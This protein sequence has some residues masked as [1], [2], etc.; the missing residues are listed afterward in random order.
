[1]PID[2]TEPVSRKKL[3]L[4]GVIGI[5]AAAIVVVTGI[6]S[7]EKSNADLRTWTDEQAVPSVAV[8][9]PEAR[10]QASTLELPWR[11]EAY[12]RAPIY[13]RVNGYV[14]SWNVDIG[15]SVKSG[16]LL[17]EIEAPDLDQQLLQARADLT[18]AQASAK[19]SEATLERRKTLLS[20][21]FV[22]HQEIDERTADLAN[23]RAS[24]NSGQANVDRLE[25]LASYKKIVAPFDGV[26][27]ARNTDVGA[28]INAGASTGPAMFVVSDIR[29]LRV[30]I[31]V[32]QN[33]VP[34]VRMGASAAISVPEYPDQTFPAK[35][36]SSSQ[37]VDVSTGTTRIQLALDNPDHKLMPGSYATVNLNLVRD[38]APL[39]IPAS[40]L[41]F[42]SKG[43]RVATVGTDD[44]IKFK[45]VTIARDLGKD[46]ELASGLA[47]DDR[48]IVA[49]P[50][51]MVDGDKVRVTGPKDGKPATA[52]SAQDKKG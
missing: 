48:V 22:S 12:S 43:L 25:A 50:D 31:N 24:V 36:E 19:L 16:Q 13:A 34:L 35:V 42:N 3:G 30:Y 2:Q 38:K 40:A 23:K 51:G 41:L 45:T 39:Y 27:T 9:L 28:L 52:S 46:I 7:R 15:A 32:P 6:A 49:P 1:M 10:A 17:A 44:K 4:F 47:A 20:S 33:Y 37:S 11:L 18:S 5:C 8:I 21:N 26:V 14:K 29:K